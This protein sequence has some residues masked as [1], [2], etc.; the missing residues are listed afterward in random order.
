MARTVDAVRADGPGEGQLTGTDAHG[1]EQ[2]TQPKPPPRPDRQGRPGSPEQA[3]A[4]QP[5]GIPESD[6]PS[7]PSNSTK[8]AGSSGKAG[9]SDGPEGEPSHVAPPPGWRRTALAVPALVV[10]A[11]ALLA[12]FVPLSNGHA[13]HQSHTCHW[14]P[15]PWTLWAVGYG[16]LAAALA[17]VAL[18]VALGRY[19]RRRGWDAEA[20]WQGRL[21][22]GFA[23]VA[24]LLALL[25]A[26]VVLLTHDVSADVTAKL[27]R[28][29]CEGLGLPRG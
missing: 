9:R 11:G 28:P 1:S 18:R 7:E 5:S 26:A 4:P 10:L 15:V 27:G 6:K 22:T 19:A 25:S 2:P 17:A 12:A 24:G 3:K 21:A 13:S 20:A 16:G 14:L 8:D 29:L 23:L